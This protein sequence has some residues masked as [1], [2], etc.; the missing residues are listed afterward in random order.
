MAQFGYKN[1][2]TLK[3]L[4]GV[5]PSGYVTFIFN[6]ECRRTSDKHN[7]CESGLFELLERDNKEKADYGF[8]P[9]YWKRGKK[10]EG[11]CKF[12][13]SYEASNKPQ[14]FQN[15]EVSIASFYVASCW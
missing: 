11:N 6:Y 14:N 3:V 5:A 8:K 7:T 9:I 1:R 2:N 13:T 12:V 4:A 10:Y 15:F